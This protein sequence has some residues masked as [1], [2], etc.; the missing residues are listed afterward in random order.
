MYGYVVSLLIAVP[1]Y[2]QHEY[3]HALIADLER[4]GAD[5]LIIDN[6]GDYPKIGSE[7]VVTPGE[8]LGWAKGSDVGFRTAFDEGYTH[9]MTLNNDTRLSKGFAAGLLDPSL[10]KDA[11]IVGPM[12]DQ[13][14]PCAI[15]EL[16]PAAA[17]YVPRPRY[18]AVPAVEGT[19]LMMSRECWDALGGMDLHSFGRYGWGIDLD[20]ALR[21]RNAGY[22]VYVTEM[23]YINHFGGKTAK[24]NFGSW[25]YEWNAN[26]ALVR[27]LGRVHGRKWRDK[28]DGALMGGGPGP[29]GWRARALLTA[30]M[31]GEAGA[32]V[33]RR[34]SNS[35]KR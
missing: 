9:A 8:N 2:G 16:Q 35:G 30:A 34:R 4:E 14:F 20:L 32:F 26:Y 17:D 24:A 5:Y 7:R 29:S 22:G 21:A 23:A 3:T 33:D 19:A 15:P 11:G 18:R 6:R 1:V 31:A 12:I 25:R 28:F 27:G 13:G 10:P